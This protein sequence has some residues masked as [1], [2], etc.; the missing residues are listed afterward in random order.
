MLS[1]LD[2]QTDLVLHVDYDQQRTKRGTLRDVNN[3]IT[4]IKDSCRSSSMVPQVRFSRTEK[5]RNSHI[6][7]LSNGQCKSKTKPPLLSSFLKTESNKSPSLKTVIKHGT[8]V[9]HQRLIPLI[10]EKSIWKY[11][12]APSEKLSYVSSKSNSRR[13]QIC[14]F[15]SPIRPQKRTKVIRFDRSSPMAMFL[16]SADRLSGRIQS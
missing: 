4:K 13:P 8:A 5:S 1:Q 2:G 15:S 7:E 14:A 11:M 12:I 16:I 9:R 3:I 10:Q 6:P